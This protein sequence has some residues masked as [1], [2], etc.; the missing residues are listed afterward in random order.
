VAV[1][2]IA[3]ALWAANMLAIALVPGLRAGLA[4]EL[5]SIRAF[6]LAGT[7]VR[8]LGVRPAAYGKERW[9]TFWVTVAYFPLLPLGRFRV[10]FEEPRGME[11]RWTPLERTPL[12]PAELLRTLFYGYVVFPLGV[13]WPWAIVFAPLPRGDVVLVVQAGFIFVG[14]AWLIG[15]LWKLRTWDQDRKRPAQR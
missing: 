4:R 8:L 13:G 2:M 14:L 10:R 11:A 15:S 9:V 5:R 12:V 1:V 3:V 7:G 6:D